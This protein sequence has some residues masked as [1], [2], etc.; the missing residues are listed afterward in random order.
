MLV[1]VLFGVNLLKAS[2]LLM[3]CSNYTFSPITAVFFVRLSEV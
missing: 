3:K 1:S 2:S